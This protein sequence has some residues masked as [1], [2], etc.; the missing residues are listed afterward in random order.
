MSSV[1][2]AVFHGTAA[3]DASG[4]S[5][6]VGRNRATCS[7][8]NSECSG[9]DQNHASTDCLHFVRA[10]GKGCAHMNAPLRSKGDQ[11]SGR[12]PINLPETDNI[13]PFSVQHSIIEQAKPNSAFAARARRYFLFL[14][15]GP[16]WGTRGL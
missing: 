7:V 13:A 8:G 10:E 12:S 1:C 6:T 2:G 9:P 5:S 4:Y 15:G 3:C 11:V 14:E 16:G